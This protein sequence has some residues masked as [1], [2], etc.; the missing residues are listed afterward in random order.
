VIS[1]LEVA[2]LALANGNFALALAIIES[3][4]EQIRASEDVLFIY[5]LALA[6]SGRLDDAE[7]AFLTILE[8]NN[9]PRVWLELADV[10]V[11]NKK[12]SDAQVSYMNALKSD[13]PPDIVAKITRKIEFVS[14]IK[15]FSIS[16]SIGAAPDTNVNGATSS[17]S[18]RIFGTE[19][20]VNE[21]GRASSGIG[22]A[23]NFGL[24][25]VKEIAD[26]VFLV[27]V[28]SA[29]LSD[30]QGSRLDDH[31]VRFESGASIYFRHIFYNVSAVH[32]RREIAGEMYSVASGVKGSSS[33]RLSE[34]ASVSI[35]G[36]ALD[37]SHNKRSDLN[38]W[39]NSITLQPFYEVSDTTT[40]SL[41]ASYI[42]D[43]SAYRPHTSTGHQFGFLLSSQITGK[44]YASAAVSRSSFKF[45]EVDP[46]YGS[47]REDTL[48]RLSVFSRYNYDL[49]FGF[50]PVMRLSKSERK[51]AHE[52]HAY[53]RVNAMIG[54]E[55]LF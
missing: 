40:A 46:A 12:Y 15:D 45:S 51:S 11:E 55:R 19:F 20:K 1:P 24:R 23:T 4:T 38:G 6:R 7:K 8:N 37:V 54:I 39:E 44:I 31:I 18:V 22:L 32:Q 27:N 9:L 25:F 36:E 43:Q 48:W 28:A 10:Q 42:S 33:F 3:S 41:W 2:R 47:R 17:D 14:G 53:D 21:D 5:G 49:G 35:F 30:Y 52:L 26:K 50:F 34:R 29:Y 16:F 13:L